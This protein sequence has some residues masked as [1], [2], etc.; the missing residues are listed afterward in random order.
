MQKISPPPGF[1]PRTVQPV[2]S[3]TD[4]AIPAPERHQFAI[5]IAAFVTEFIVTKFTL[6][7]MVFS[8]L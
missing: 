5:V 7:T 4:D 8:F 6:V 1:D 3:H 2:A